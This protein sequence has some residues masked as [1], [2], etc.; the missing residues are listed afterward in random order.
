MDKKQTDK[1]YEE[2]Y[3]ALRRTRD[4]RVSESRVA[5]LCVLG[6]AVMPWLMMINQR[7][8]PPCAKPTCS[9]VISR[10]EP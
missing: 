7:L 2:A 9:S 3:E 10:A 8:T 1:L 5:A 6:G 4:G